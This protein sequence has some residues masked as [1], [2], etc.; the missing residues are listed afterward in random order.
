MIVT[1]MAM[2]MLNT[3]TPVTTSTP[4]DTHNPPYCGLYCIKAGAHIISHPVNMADLIQPKYFT[5]FASTSAN[6]LEAL[7]DVGLK[8]HSRGNVTLA[9]LQS[10]SRPMILHVR[11]TGYKQKFHH[12]ILF[13][14]YT[15]TGKARVYDP[16]M[17]QAELEE[18]ELLSIWDGVAIT[19]HRQ[20]EPFERPQIPYPWL[21]MIGIC[22][23]V[24]YATKKLHPLWRMIIA[25]GS[26]V[27]CMHVILPTGLFRT[28]R[29]AVGNVMIAHFEPE[30][31]EIDY[32]EFSQA[33]GDGQALVIDARLA[34][35]YNHGH[36]PNA[37]SLPVYSGYVRVAR[38]LQE[39]QPDQPIVMYC[40][41][42]GCRWADSMA[43]RFV[44]AGFTNVRIFRGGMHEWRKRHE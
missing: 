43:S 27:I 5:G 29:L 14:G 2:M 40:Q 33:V 24:L 16:P 15:D 1:A 31:D 38:I 10:A 34:E 35:D 11:P 4:D 3:I 13:L 39:Q 28:N 23:T 37:M 42:E 7:N 30:V 12:W 26:L 17:D 18:A 19:I 44:N 22:C 21:V 36:I 25:I 41:S 9:Q 20:N 32:E 6:L 8:G